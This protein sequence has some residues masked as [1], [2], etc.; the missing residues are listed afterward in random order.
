MSWWRRVKY[1][2]TC[3]E[4]WSNLLLPT[5]FNCRILSSKIQFW[6]MWPWEKWHFTPG[7]LKLLQFFDPSLWENIPKWNISSLDKYLIH[8]Y[9]IAIMLP[10]RDSQTDPPDFGDSVFPIIFLRVQNVQKTSS[11]EPQ[12]FPV[13]PSTLTYA[14]QRWPLQIAISEPRQRE[15]IS[16]RFRGGEFFCFKKAQKKNWLFFK[17][18]FWKHS[19]L[20]SIEITKEG[21]PNYPLFVKTSLSLPANPKDSRL[22]PTST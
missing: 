16:P 7:Q 22:F 8:S 1:Q 6:M 10:S 9:S 5:T 3:G 21:L 2:V 4:S 14:S 18:I 17:M 13:P 20:W 12:A 11:K 19:E 15:K